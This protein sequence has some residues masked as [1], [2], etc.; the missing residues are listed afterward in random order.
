M[1][2]ESEKYYIKA[3]V[4]LSVDEASIGTDRWRGPPSTPHLDL[5]EIPGSNLQIH[6][7]N[8]ACMFK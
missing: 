3:V 8:D 4:N 1:T 2:R 6:L 5:A 7:I